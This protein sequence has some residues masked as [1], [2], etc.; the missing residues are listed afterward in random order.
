MY[1]VEGAQV[2]VEGVA[3]A[4]VAVTI[5][6]PRAHKNPVRFKARLLEDLAHPGVFPGV[7]SVDGS[8]QSKAGANG[9]G[10]ATGSNHAPLRT[11]LTISGPSLPTP[12]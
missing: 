11:W 9:S 7:G 2:V 10:A 3:P 5:T 12:G 8:L 1:V 6:N 4:C